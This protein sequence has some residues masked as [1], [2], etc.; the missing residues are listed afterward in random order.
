[1]DIALGTPNAKQ[2]LFLTDKHRHVGFG[3]ARG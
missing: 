3:G 1:M 2:V